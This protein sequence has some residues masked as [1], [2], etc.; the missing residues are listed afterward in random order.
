MKLPLF[1]AYRDPDFL[2]PFVPRLHGDE[3]MK[4]SLSLLR[5][6]VVSLVLTTA[7]VLHAG[8]SRPQHVFIVSIDQGNPDALQEFKMPVLQEM[9]REGAHSWNAFT[10]VPSVTLPSHVSMLTGV[11]IQ[12]HQVLWNGYDP[13]Q[14]P[15]SV[16]TI[17]SL[18]KEQGLVTAMFVSKQKFQHLNLPDSV[19]AFVWP[20]PDDNALAVAAAFAKEVGTLKPNLCFIHFRDP[21]SAGH[22][23]GVFVHPRKSRPSKKLMRLWASSGRPSPKPG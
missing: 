10:I 15:L 2:T 12:K 20:Q 17:F 13:E 7:H 23:H 6:L 3:S 11:G 8:E 1:S 16:P 18:A 22:A 14:P 4:I 9:V 19:D 5:V 21:D